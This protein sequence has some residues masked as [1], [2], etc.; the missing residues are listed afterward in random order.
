MNY[1]G[2]NNFNKAPFKDLQFFKNDF[3]FILIS[4]S[5]RF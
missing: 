3:I 4:F 2:Y 5:Y 1:N